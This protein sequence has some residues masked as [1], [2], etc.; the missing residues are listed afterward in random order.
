MKETLIERTRRKAHVMVHRGLLDVDQA[1]RFNS[2]FSCVD[3]SHDE[4]QIPARYLVLIMPSQAL[5][6]G[7]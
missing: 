5:T 2:H 3:N 1:T 4:V 7:G 6:S